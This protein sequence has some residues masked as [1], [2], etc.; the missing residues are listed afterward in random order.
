MLV[1]LSPSSIPRVET[2]GIDGRVFAF[3]LGVSLFTGIAFG[4][5]PALQL[6]RRDAGESLREGERGS[7]EGPGRSRLRMLL[8]GSE[9][10]LALVLLVCAGLM[11]RSFLALQ[12][13][14]PGFNPSNVLTM[15]V[16]VAGSGEAEPQRRSAFF[17]EALRR[18]RALPGVRSAGAINHLPLGGDIWGWSFSVEGRPIPAPGE[19]PDAA[20]R[21]VLPGYFQ[22]MGIPILRGRDIAGSDRLD[23][24]GAIVINEFLA[25][26]Q[27]PGENPLGKRITFDD[28]DKDPQWLTVVGVIK[29]AVRSDWAAEPWGEV[30]MPYLQNRN[31]LEKASS[32]WEYLTLVVRAKGDPAALTAA[33]RRAIASLDRNVTIAE[34]QTMERVVA[35]ATAQPRFYL[36]LLGTFAGTALILAALGIYGVMSYS[37][38][39]R[40]HEIG[41]RV[42]LGADQSDVLRLVV[43]EAMTVAVVGAGV[44]LAAALA[45]TRLMRTLLYGVGSTDL[46]TFLA[47]PVVLMFVALAASYIPAHRATRID[48]LTALRCD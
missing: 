42:A 5:L 21:V 43:R 9:F 8:V 45:L 40:T 11:I 26:Q 10:A 35:D 39:R 4:L 48:P 44:G 13:I 7:T 12:G 22:A 6:S 38:S 32:H 25:N 29:N 47:V 1:A 37:V 31:Y 3:A 2:I 28:Q 36:L 46:L 14:D 24:P 18:V 34:V 30:Y 41:I 33:I 27:W 16:S 17:E 23:A 15:T 20:Y 19:S